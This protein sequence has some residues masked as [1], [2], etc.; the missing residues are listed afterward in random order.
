MRVFAIVKRIKQ[1]TIVEDADWHDSF[2]MSMYRM[3]GTEIEIF[4]RYSGKAAWYDGVSTIYTF[5]K[6]WLKNFRI[7]EE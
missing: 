2:T 4:P 7:E 3:W 6:S 5:H 1:N